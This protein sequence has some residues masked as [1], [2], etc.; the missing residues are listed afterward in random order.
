MVT[1]AH[2]LRLRT[3]VFVQQVLDPATFTDR[4]PLAIAAW[5]PTEATLARATEEEA[6]AAGLRG[7]H[8]EHD[9]ADGAFEKVALGHRFGPVW[10][11]CWF[12]L[13]A[14]LPE[15]FTARRVH[16]RF[17]CGTEA[18]LWRRGEPVAGFDPNRDLAPLGEVGHAGQAVDLFVEAHCNHPLGVATFW[19]DHDATVQRWNERRPGRL[20]R[21]ELVVVDETVRELAVAMRFAGALVEELGDASPR[22]NRLRVAIE[23]ARGLVDPTAPARDAFTALTVL[24][25]ALGR[26]AAPSA[27]TCFAV[28]H[29][30]LDTAW[31]WT[32]ARTREKSLRTWANALD[33][34]ERDDDF[35]FASS[36]PQQLA[37]L[38]RDAPATFERVERAVAAGRVELVGATWV[39]PDGNLPSGES[40]C[41]QLAFGSLWL[42]EHF[43]ERADGRVLFLPDTFGFC[44]SWPQLARLAGLDTFVTNKLWWSE[45]E[46]FD[47]CH[48][49]W[50]GI[51]GSTLLAHVTPGQDYNA[52]NTPAELRRGERV[53]AERDRVDV[54]VWLQP[55][56][57][58]DGGGG[59]TREQLERA[60]LAADAEGLPRVR[61]SGMRVFREALHER[62]EELERRGLRLPV[63]D[64]ELYLENHRG[65]LTTHAALKR[66]NARAEVWLRG[67]EVAL[68]TWPI[69]LEDDAY[70]RLV[71]ALKSD[72]ATVL[73]QQFHD[74][75]PGSCTGDVA[76][77]ARAAYERL[78]AAWLRLGGALAQ[79]LA[80]RL[81]TRG[82]ERPFLAV[83]LS[84]APR[85]GW[86]GEA[87]T[88]GWATA[89]PPLGFV[90]ADA[91]APLPDGVPVPRA[92]AAGDEG[93]PRLEHEV[94]GRA[95][96]VELGARGGLASLRLDGDERAAPGFELGA[97][98]LFDDR[99]IQWEAWNVDAEDRA[100]PLAVDAPATWTPFEAGPARRGFECERA[101]G[102]NSAVRTRV[103]CEAGD[104]AVH[105]EHA[106]EWREDRRMLRADFAARVR[107][108]RATCEIPFGELE[109]PLTANDAGERMA[110]EVPIQRFVDVTEPGRGLAVIVDCR[111]GVSLDT[112]DDGCARVGVSLLRATAWPDA[113]ADR[114]ESEAGV[115]HRVRFTLVPHDGDAHAAGVLE[116]AE[117]APL[118]WSAVPLAPADATP[119]DGRDANSD[120]NGAGAPSR[121]APLEL[122]TLSGAARPQVASIAPSWHGDALLVRL[123]ERGGGRGRVAVRFGFE[124]E[125][126]DAVDLIER[127]RPEDAVERDGET[128]AVDLR[129]F[130]VVTLRVVRAR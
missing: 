110:F 84:S 83:N 26:G 74:V 46:S 92:V 122:V 17:D 31:L 70:E 15:R 7:D 35:H 42:R 60:H 45:R 108:R 119:R 18:T 80:E 56:G 125:R 29:A 2:R 54:G 116:R 71:A 66:G 59:P 43:G 33:L 50:R 97:L 64:G 39:E 1:D 104:A 47:H 61:L 93:A 88:G 5:Q 9:H 128:Y 85:T 28:G 105:L 106:I 124:V 81:D 30:H 58:G 129:P 100:R 27:T 8:G 51:D 94:D 52:T 112:T 73:L 99:P 10:S 109:R 25:E 76:A 68:A 16:L 24:R 79:R 130:Q 126:V 111:H 103:W 13:R 4:L 57:Y 72:W 44:A 63:V 115:R 95:L 14:H 87:S 98:R 36:Q 114:V 107:A 101:V 38:K 75:L 78:D 113:K 41:R 90:V 123:V 117:V 32:T 82:A 34:L 65:T 55:F 3:D 118:G 49:T 19:W 96:V 6:R 22:A 53:L 121:F 23:R 69:G 11:S 48:F 102:A 127:P 67:L 62:V 37:W 20:E 89:V 77:E 86:F 21:A 120:E 91:A 12:R 40:L